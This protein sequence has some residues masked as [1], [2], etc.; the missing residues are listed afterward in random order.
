MPRLETVPRRVVMM[1][2]TVG[3]LLALVALLVWAVAAI[4]RLQVRGVV[5]EGPD[6]SAKTAARQCS[7]PQ[8]RDTSRHLQQPRASRH[9]RFSCYDH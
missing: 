1:A 3:T 8:V 7:H 2:A 4:P 5:I 6:A 9:D